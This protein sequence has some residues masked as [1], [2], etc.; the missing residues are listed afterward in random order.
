[1][2][3]YIYC[4][5]LLIIICVILLGCT[6]K[7]EEKSYTI[8]QYGDYETDQQMFYTIED[9]NNNLIII[10]GGWDYNADNV[11]QI[12]AQ[13][14]N[15]VTAWIITHPHPDHA[16]AFNVIAENPDGIVID[17]I[18]ST[19]VHYDRY[20]ETAQ[21]Y[22][23]FEVCE[24]YM[25]LISGMD[26]VHMV[27]E[28]DT[29]YALG[30]T[31]DVIHA[32]DD[33]VDKFNVNICNNGSMCFIVSGSEDKMLFCADTQEQVEEDIVS[34]HKDELDVDYIQLGHH[35]NWGMTTA[36][37]DNINPKAVFFDA[38]RFIFETEGYDAPVLKK[39]FEDRGVDVYTYETQPNV[40]EFK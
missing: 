1:M 8:T 23:V 38:S 19:D 5:S 20:K 37:Y 32:W 15:H 9:N 12:I 33:R 39:Y 13:H 27:N 14:D 22:D 40:I 35:G 6:K 2:K 34:R 24:K 10:D 36:F 26:N 7:E 28:G 29:F 31:F 21:W 18:Y 3:R 4:I 17:D 11:R 25:E 30:L 16:G